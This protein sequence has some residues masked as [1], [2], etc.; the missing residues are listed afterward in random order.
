MMLISVISINA[1]ASNTPTIKVSEVSSVAGSS[2][3]IKIEISNNPGIISMLLD[4]SYDA[5]CLTLKKV[6]NGTVL[7]GATHNINAL[8]VNPYTLSWADDIATEN[9]TNSGTIVTF[10]FEISADAPEGKLPITVTYDNDNAAIYDKD[11]ELVDF[12]VVN[13]GVTVISS[14]PGDIN[15]D[16]YVDSKDAVLLAQHLA[17]W[18][19]SI[20]MSTAD[21]NNDGNVDS[22]DAV[23]LAQYLAKWNVTLG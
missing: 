7:N 16:S 20:D 22:K 4:V 23:L 12:A 2:V 19:V 10:S 1:S 17:K 9:N 13:G 5:D 8:T 3:D 18:N 11:M 6:T 15:G 14:K 21:C